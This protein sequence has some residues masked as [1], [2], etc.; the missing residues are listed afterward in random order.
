MLNSGT[1]RQLL[2]FKAMVGAGKGADSKVNK[3]ILRAKT[4]PKWLFDDL[5]VTDPFTLKFQKLV[6]IVEN[7]ARFGNLNG[8]DASPFER[9]HYIKITMY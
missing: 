3:T 7:V 9:F 8:L 4:L 6:H 1:V 2:Y 5:E